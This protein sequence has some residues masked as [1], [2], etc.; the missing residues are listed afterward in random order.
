MTHALNQ[1]RHL[2]EIEGMHAWLAEK[3]ESDEDLVSRQQ[4]YR[5]ELALQFG[6][7]PDDQ[8][9]RAA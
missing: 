6:L 3:I 4:A 2:E 8:A 5:H 9:R 7:E 1:S